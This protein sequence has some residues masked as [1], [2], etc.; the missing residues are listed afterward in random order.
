MTAEDNMNC[1][2]RDITVTARDGRVSHLDQVYIRGSH[3]RYFIVPDML[4]L[5]NTM[6][7]DR[8]YTDLRMTEMR[9]CSEP[10]MSAEEVSVLPEVAPLSTEPEDKEVDPVDKRKEQE[11]C[12]DDECKEERKMRV[13]CQQ[14]AWDL[15]ISLRMIR[16]VRSWAVVHASRRSAKGLA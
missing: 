8:I 14:S 9:P 6:N 12:L 5:V 15:H 4:R 13:S 11:A 16:P 10:E 2:L 3:V 7:Q 1:Q